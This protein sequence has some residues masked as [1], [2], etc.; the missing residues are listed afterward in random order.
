MNPIKVNR[1]DFLSRL[2][3]VQPGLS[4][5][6]ILEQSS[7][8][9]FRNGSIVTYNDEVSCRCAS[10]LP[11][12]VTG[13]VKAKPLLAILQK[14]EEDEIQVCVTA[15]GLEIRGKRKGAAIALEAEVLLAVDTVEPP[16]GWSP[17]PD[18]FCKAVELAGQ[19]A[20]QD[21]SRFALTCI[22]L[23]PDFIEACDNFQLAR[24]TLATGLTS[25]VLVRHTSV[26]PIA[27]LGM[28]EFSETD[29]WLHFRNHAKLILSCRRYLEEY[30]DLTALL[31]VSGAPAALPKGL[32][33]AV[34]KAEVFTGENPDN[35]YVR[36]ELRPG[37]LR[38][39]GTGVSG[40]YWQIFDM[41]AYRGAALAFLITPKLLAEI[42]TR[43]NEVQV[44][45]D[46]LKVEGGKW[47]YVAYLGAVTDGGN[48][49][50]APAPQAAAPEP[51]PAIEEYDDPIPY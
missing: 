13:A 12:E 23:H 20:G 41:P 5:R 8:V 25:P 37:E 6:E 10:G 47:R 31:D 22:H 29:S 2:L 46:R 50:A 45:K 14:L 49:Q 21:Q 26:K 35:N 39:R 44:T 36:V 3:T 32:V 4:Q 15:K 38:L 42:V 1:E 28:T 34:D 18:D 16:K 33:E 17:L 9:V 48:G 19:C 7:C 11:K 30:P 40:H 51:A 43:H 27:Q 24:Y